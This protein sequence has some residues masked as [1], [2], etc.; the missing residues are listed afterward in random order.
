MSSI[1]IDNDNSIMIYLSCKVINILD[2]MNKMFVFIIAA[3]V[4][5][6]AFILAFVL[7][8]KKADSESVSPEVFSS[9]LATESGAQLVDVRT[10]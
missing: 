4:F 8:S 6:V 10:A 9:R 2:V 1:I 5:A 7:G 3:V